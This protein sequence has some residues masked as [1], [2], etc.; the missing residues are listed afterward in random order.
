MNNS[1][2]SSDWKC[3]VSTNCLIEEW[4]QMAGIKNAGITVNGI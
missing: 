4:F 1:F 3:F 2:Q